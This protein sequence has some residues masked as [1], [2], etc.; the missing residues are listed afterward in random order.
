MIVTL[1]PYYSL[2]THIALAH[3]GT[4]LLLSGNG[5]LRIYTLLEILGLTNLP[6]AYLMHQ[7]HIIGHIM[8]I[9]LITY[10]FLRV[11]SPWTC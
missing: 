5:V 9:N 2:S 7:D 1:S 4:N 6:T 8:T 3:D 11:L 10:E